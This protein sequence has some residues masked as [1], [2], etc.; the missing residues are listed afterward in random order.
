MKTKEISCEERSRGRNPCLHRHTSTRQMPNHW[1]FQFHDRVHLIKRSTHPIHTSNNM[2][3]T[4]YR[5]VLHSRH[6]IP[7]S[8]KIQS[9]W[10]AFP[11]WLTDAHGPS[12]TSPLDAIHQWSE[13][14]IL[15]IP[16]VGL[17]NLPLVRI[18]NSHLGVAESS[19]V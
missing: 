6:S 16:T 17:C 19:F 18:R 9:S 8:P 1:V 3:A 7:T 15:Y 14:S 2:L 11:R 5:T 10:D 12:T 4:Q 13:L